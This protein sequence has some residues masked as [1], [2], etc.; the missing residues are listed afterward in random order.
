[1][2]KLKKNSKDLYRIKAYSSIFVLNKFKEENIHVYD[3]KQID[4]FTYT[5]YADS[6][7]EKK[8][9]KNFN[10][11]KLIRSST[12]KGITKSLLKKKTTLISIIFSILLFCFSS[13]RLYD[14]KING[15]SNEINSKITSYLKSN[16]VYRFS[17]MPSIDKLKTLEESLYD[18]LINEVE[19]IEITKNGLVVMIKYEKRRSPIILPS[20]KKSL[21]AKRSGVIERIEIE[22]GTPLVKVGEMVDKDQILVSE[23]IQINDKESL[24]TFTLGKVYA[25]TWYDIN[26]V[27]NNKGEK[28]ENTMALIQLADSLV[29]T[30]DKVLD[31]RKLLKYKENGN[32]VEASFHYTVIEDI[33]ISL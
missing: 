21:I 23:D 7:D 14:L 25:Y 20:L 24:K 30:K 1:M 8:L 13:T 2:L 26:V 16:G 15:S 19:N 6:S 11:I 12:I 29:L 4:D 9:F 10:D 27:T 31:D 22:Y 32:Q 17:S 33:A 5:F 18:N 28:S 3:F